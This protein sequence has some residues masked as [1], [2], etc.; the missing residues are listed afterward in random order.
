M[1]VYLRLYVRICIKNTACYNALTLFFKEGPAMAKN[2]ITDAEYA[3]MFKQMDKEALATLSAAILVTAVFWLT[4]ALTHDINATVLYMPL[5]FVLSCIGGYL[6]S[7][8]VVIFLV[9]K[10][11]RNL[12]LKVRSLKDETTA[13]KSEIK[14]VK[15]EMNATE[16]KGK[17]HTATN[18]PTL[19]SKA[20]SNSSAHKE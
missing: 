3:S 6:F 8:V 2:E 17:T 7:I 20:F 10:L 19:S 13:V 9:K 18:T 16:S 11:M 15:S 12:E 1:Q 14:A 4:I 5:W